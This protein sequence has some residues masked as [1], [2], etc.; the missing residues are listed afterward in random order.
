MSSTS[1]SAETAYPKYPEGAGPEGGEGAEGDMNATL[2]ADDV[3]DCGE[4]P[5]L[6]AGV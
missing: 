5:S 1:S 6:A 2:D 3:P 4:A